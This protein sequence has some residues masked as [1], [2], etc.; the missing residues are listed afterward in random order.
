MIPHTQTCW[1]IHGV[2]VG[3]WPSVP[4]LMAAHT[5][6]NSKQC[7]W[8]MGTTS[9]N[10][11]HEINVYSPRSAS[12]HTYFAHNIAQTLYRVTLLQSITKCRTHTHTERERDK[13][14]HTPDSSLLCMSLPKAD[15]FGL[16]CTE[17]IMTQALI[18][19]SLVHVFNKHAW[20]SSFRCFG[21]SVSVSFWWTPAGIRPLYS[22]SLIIVLASISSMNRSRYSFR[23]SSAAWKE[24]IDDKQPG[25]QCLLT[26]CRPT[27]PTLVRFT[28][29][30][31]RVNTRRAYKC[32][33]MQTAFVL[34][35]H[36]TQVWVT[37]V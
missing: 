20:R 23:T 5:A 4:L 19:A 1:T 11:T 15:I 30:L 13:H 17:V 35:T 36:V 8:G 3:V 26:N 27:P 25:Q 24:K 6:N 31:M 14:T 33:A 7:N 10:D 12:G 21:Q 28:H 32:T 22:N 34:H 18:N 37:P 9:S 16:P 2:R 29:A